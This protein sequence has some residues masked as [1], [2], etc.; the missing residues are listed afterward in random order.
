M[1]P[2]IEVDSTIL[3]YAVRYALPRRSYAVTDV[4]NAIVE[5]A[6]SLDEP[7]RR[8]L[9]TDIR[10]GLAGG[11]RSTHIAGHGPTEAELAREWDRALDALEPERARN[12]AA[13]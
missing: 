4:V 3:G 5:H 12:G 2:R 8:V 9:A 7:F 1:S 11:S 13:A 10:I 6:P